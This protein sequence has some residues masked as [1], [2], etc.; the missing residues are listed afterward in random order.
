MEQ[1][2]YYICVLSIVFTGVANKEI[3]QGKLF[4]L[5]GKIRENEFC[6][7]VGTLLHVLRHCTC[8]LRNIKLV[9]VKLYVCC[10]GPIR[11]FLTEL[12][13]P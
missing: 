1:S 3:S 8:I 13:S 10:F 9:K 11:A 6:K 5:S 12:P 4:M 7:V 2:L